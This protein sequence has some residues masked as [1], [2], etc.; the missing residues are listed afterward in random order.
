MWGRCATDES[1]GLL[2]HCSGKDDFSH[3]C[4]GDAIWTMLVVFSTVWLPI[5]DLNNSQWTQDFILSHWMR[6]VFL[7]LTFM[8]FVLRVSLILPAAAIEKL[9]TMFD[10]WFTTMPIKLPILLLCILIV[11]SKLVA[12][13]QK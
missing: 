10:S 4:F 13:S 3:Y 11:H 2:F 12:T 5:I 8:W 6:I 1:C 7:Y 9:I